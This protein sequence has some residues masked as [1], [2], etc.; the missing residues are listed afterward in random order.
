[1]LIF[2][3]RNSTKIGKFRFV[4]VTSNLSLCTYAFIRCL[5]ISKNKLTCAFEAHEQNELSTPGKNSRSVQDNS[6]VLVTWMEKYAEMHGDRMPNTNQILLPY[7][8]TKNDLYGKY[9][10]ECTTKP[11][12]RSQF[13]TT[14]KQHFPHVKIKKTNSFTKCTICTTLER[15][16][17]KTTSVETRSLYR[18]Q[19][20]AHNRRQMMER[21]YYYSKREESRKSPGQYMSLIIDGMDQAKTNLPHFTGRR[22][23]NMNAADL[24]KTHV[25]GI[26][27]HGHGGFHTFV[28]ICQYSHDPNLTLNVLLKTFLHTSEKN[29]NRLPATLYLQAD[30]CFRENKNKFVLAFCELLIRCEIFTE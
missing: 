1:M 21:K 25:T 23:K 27:N 30:N 4:S 16:I 17:A 11:V 3:I 8:L 20:E 22:P 6:L 24:L 29:G 28:D 12:S 2:Y 26:I 9:K 5:N 19:K 7:G 15:Q 14:W 18:Q 10:E 13:Y